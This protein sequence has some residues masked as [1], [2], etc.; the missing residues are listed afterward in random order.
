MYN[1]F[2]FLCVD[3][4]KIK[5]TAE[6]AGRIKT[7]PVSINRFPYFGGYV[8]LFAFLCSKFYKV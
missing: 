8:F 4:G 2:I 7:F 3:A 1:L 6:G 5:N